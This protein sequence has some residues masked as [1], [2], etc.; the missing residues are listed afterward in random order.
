[1][2][3]KEI[4][5]IV[6]VIVCIV[7]TIVVMMQESKNQGLGGALGGG[8]SNNDTYWSKNK[9]HSLEGRLAMITR[10]TAVIMIIFAILINS[11]FL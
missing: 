3:A 10:I 11:K 5:E 2:S 1:M 7:L 6:F 9:K 8:M 4:V